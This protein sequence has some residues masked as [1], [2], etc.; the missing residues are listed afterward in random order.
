[1]DLHHLYNS[2]PERGA[3]FYLKAAIGKA[4]EMSQR[5]VMVIILSRFC[6]IVVGILES[7]SW[8]GKKKLL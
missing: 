4:W 3:E 8:R 1:M 7:H 2:V 5:F 6:M